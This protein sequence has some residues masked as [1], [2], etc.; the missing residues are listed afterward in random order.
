MNKF[1][2]I[3]MRYLLFWTPSFVEG[4]VH[5]FMISITSIF[6]SY[7]FMDVSVEW[8]EFGKCEIRLY[9]GSNMRGFL[10]TARY[11]SMESSFFY[12]PI[13]CLYKGRSLGQRTSS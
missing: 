11:A 12:I 4:D 8:I 9:F 13:W 3:F 2:L 10:L 1:L 5:D 7:N 6:S